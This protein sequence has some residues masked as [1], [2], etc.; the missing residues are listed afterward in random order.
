M[1]PLQSYTSNPSRYSAFSMLVGES[2]LSIDFDV[3]YDVNPRQRLD[4]YRRTDD[5]SRGPVALFLYGGSWRHGCRS[6]YGFVG[7]AL[8]SQGI[9][10][11]V[12][13]YRLFPEVTWPAF[14]EDAA[15]AFRWVAKHLALNGR[16]PVILIGHSAGAHLAAH[17]ALD[18]RWIG[19]L[20]VGGLVGLAGPYTFDPKAWASTSDIFA[21]AGI[22]EI[23]RPIALVNRQA[24][25]T[26]LLHGA[27][28]DV[29]DPTVTKLF[30]GA[31]QA[32]GTA[33]TAEILPGVGHRDLIVDF[34]WPFRRRAPV[35][36]RT[37]DFI[38]T[39]QRSTAS[40]VLPR[41]MGAGLTGH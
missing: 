9:P 16:R 38:Q 14:Q 30:A 10:T 21:P 25:P 31:L 1:L 40:D 36:A 7:A 27:R 6:C 15:L 5:P 11:A 37:V 2:G 8:A 20:P 26:L 35:L 23:L 32:A 13:D 34:S 28:D 19:G 24:P 18:R 33:V 12:A 17:L 3:A 4:I 29:V 39:L 41:M 22:S